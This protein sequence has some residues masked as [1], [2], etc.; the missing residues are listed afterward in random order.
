MGETSE[1]DEVRGRAFSPSGTFSC[2]PPSTTTRRR[3]MRAMTRGVMRFESENF[4]SIAS[5]IRTES[6]RSRSARE[7]RWSEDSS[8]SSRRVRAPRSTKSSINF[9][10]NATT[11][12]ERSRRT[13]AM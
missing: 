7:W 13:Y 6:S 5:W 3:A 10:R 4:G 11:W 9:S 8:D 2:T 1:R 12:S